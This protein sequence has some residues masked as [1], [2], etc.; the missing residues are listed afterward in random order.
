MDSAIQP[1][2]KEKRVRGGYGL[3]FE[4]KDAE[5]R[6]KE[7]EREVKR[8]DDGGQNN[9]EM[10]H[11]QIKHRLERKKWREQMLIFCRAKWAWAKM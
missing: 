10:N 4:I 1:Y 6:Q 5:G 11:L 2:K 9:Q 3:G 8:Y 7:E